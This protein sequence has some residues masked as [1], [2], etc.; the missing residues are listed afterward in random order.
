MRLNGHVVQVMLLLKLK[1]FLNWALMSVLVIDPPTQPLFYI[2]MVVLTKEIYSKQENKSHSSVLNLTQWTFKRS[3]VVACSLG[4]Q[5]HSARLIVT[6]KKCCLIVKPC[7][8]VWGG[9]IRCSKSF[10]KFAG[11]V[12][13][14]ACVE[15]QT[16]HQCD[17]KKVAQSKPKWSTMNKCVEVLG[18]F[19]TPFIKPDVKCQ[20]I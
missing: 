16:R 15:F 6:T 13:L 12:S 9:Q 3:V 8:L 5:A 7:V 11:V 19:S 18:N 20:P 14:L 10:I 2:C 4:E 1:L 17:Q